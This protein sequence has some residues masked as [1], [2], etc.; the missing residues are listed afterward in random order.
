MK[1]RVWELAT[2]PSDFWTRISTVENDHLLGRQLDRDEAE[3][4]ANYKPRPKRVEE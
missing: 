4:I 2:A 1:M 3:L